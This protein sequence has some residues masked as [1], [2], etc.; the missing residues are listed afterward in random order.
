MASADDAQA[1]TLRV[2]R[3]AGLRLPS[4]GSPVTRAHRATR[5]SAPRSASQNSPTGRKRS[6]VETASARFEARPRP[7]RGPRRRACAASGRRVRIHR[8]E[9]E[10]REVVAARG[11]S[12]PVTSSMKMSASANTSVHGPV[13]PCER[14]NC[15]GAPYAGVN[16]VTLPCVCA[17]EPAE[18]LRVLH[19]LRDAEVEQLHRARVAAR[20]AEDEDVRR[21]HVAVR[22]ALAVRERERLG[23]P[24]RGA[25]A[26]A[27]PCAAAMPRGASRR[28][29][30]ARAPRPS[31]HSS[32]MYGTHVAVGRRERADVARL[33]DR[34]RSLGEL[35]E[36]RALLDEARRGAAR[37]AR[38]RRSPSA[39]EDLDR[40]RPLPDRVRRAVDDREAA[41][42]DDALDLVLLRD[43]RTDE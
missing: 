36:Q 14:E 12:L 28:R 3:T 22:D 30:T 17:N 6:S 10:L 19:D 31:S 26:P 11:G 42:A 9:R 7:R 33:A 29:A 38:P 27:R 35:G 21:L 20:I 39:R 41:F 15:S 8:R 25:R 43:G 24:A 23:R 1:P 2:R 37:V 13:A 4:S 16:D 5:P 32:T 34:R 40:D 18:L